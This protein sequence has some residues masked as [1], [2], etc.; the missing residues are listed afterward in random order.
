MI[1]VLHIIDK[2][3]N[4]GSGMHGPARQLYYRL[5]LYPAEAFTTRVI[6]LRREDTAAHL[7]QKAGIQTHCL[8]RSKF[9]LRAYFDILHHIREF[10][11][12]VLHL[13]GYAAQAMGRPAGRRMNIPTVLQEHAILSKIPPYEIV[14]DFLLGKMQT[15]TVAVSDGVADFLRRKRFI[16]GDIQVIWNGVPDKTFDTPVSPSERQALRESLGYR[17]HHILIGM[18]GRLA[19]G[20][21]HDTFLRAAAEIHNQHPDARFLI[22]GEGPCRTEIEDTVKTLHLT[23]CTQLS[24]FR[25][26]ALQIMA[27]LDIHVIASHQEGFPGV[28]VENLVTRTPMICT[29]ISAFNNFAKHNYDCLMFKPED[30]AE[31]TRELTKTIHNPEQARN[32]AEHGFK[33]AEQ[34]RMSRIAAKY[35]ELYRSILN[36]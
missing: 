5:P 25:N 20:K 31:L 14:I 12:S 19:K 6:S 17:P 8:C 28:A 7:L 21:G 16:H 32:R 13:H 9:D 2:L 35:M 24:G 18:I 10:K 30:A 4:D 34:C 23:E 27:A 36:A 1:R 15:R 26:D 33:T 29:N 11:P 22:V 3:S